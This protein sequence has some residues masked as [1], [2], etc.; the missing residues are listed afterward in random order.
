MMVLNIIPNQGVDKGST[1]V[2]I[3]GHNFPETEDESYLCK[4]GS[5]V[6]A[7]TWVAT[8]HV[9]CL[10]PARPEGEVIVEIS[11]NGTVYTNNKVI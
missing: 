8:D 3:R 9:I 10:S 6:V 11:P 2:H 7:G 4:F 5:D 1:S